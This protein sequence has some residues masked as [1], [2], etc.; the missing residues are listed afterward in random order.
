[1]LESYTIG[2]LARQAG[3]NVETIRYYQRRGLIGE[4]RRP[5]GGIRRYGEPHAE[6]LRFI[7]QAQALGFSLE[8][9]KE[10]LALEDG[11]HCREAER[12]GAIKLAAVRERLGQLRRVERALAALVDQCHRNAGRVRCPLMAALG[13]GRAVNPH[14]QRSD[15]GE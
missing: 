10:L 1:M 4:P 3:V 12:L 13:A 7:R 9:V 8:E 14:A 15:G 5:P 2:A 6:R 11:Q